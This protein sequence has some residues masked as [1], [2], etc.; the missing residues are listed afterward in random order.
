ME[1]TRAFRV[2]G[3]SDGPKVAVHDESVGITNRVFRGG[4]IPKRI[5]IT[6]NVSF[7]YTVNVFAGFR[8]DVLVRIIFRDPE[9]PAPLDNAIHLYAYDHVALHPGLYFHLEI[10]LRVGGICRV[11]ACSGGY[12]KEGV[13]AGV[14]G[15]VEVAPQ[16]FGRPSGTAVPNIGGVSGHGTCSIHSTIDTLL[17]PENGSPAHRNG[18]YTRLPAGLRRMHHIAVGIGGENGLAHIVY[19]IVVI[20]I[21]PR[22]DGNVVGIF[23]IGLEIEIVGQVTAQIIGVDDGGCTCPVRAVKAEARS[24]FRCSIAFVVLI[25]VGSGPAQIGRYIVGVGLHRA[26]VSGS[27]KVLL[28]VVEAVRIGGR[29][30]VTECKGRIGGRNL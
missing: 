19:A 6:V 3:C 29:I 24:A 25:D 13:V 21:S 16:D 8:Y 23:I 27:G 5:V 14:C 1:A 28:F 12:L 4:S 17:V 15:Q 9:V 26:G 20:G 2:H 18:I 30:R 22:V 11:K 7:P 10:R